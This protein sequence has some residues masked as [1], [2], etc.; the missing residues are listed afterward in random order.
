MNNNMDNHIKESKKDIYGL[1]KELM[2]ESDISNWQSD[3]YLRKNSIS[4]KLVNEYEFK[5]NV[6]TFKD[7][8]D[9]VL[10]YDIPFA[11]T[12]FWEDKN[13]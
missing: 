6:K 7:N 11:Y 12:P 1:A 8:I 5:Q 10:W 9:H 4:D 13:K 3:L 2:Q